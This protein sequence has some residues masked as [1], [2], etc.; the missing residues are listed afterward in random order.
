MKRREFVTLVGSLV[1]TWPLAARAQQAG[2]LPTIG[3]L[4]P[5]VVSVD[6]PRVAAFEQRLGELG[7]VDDRSGRSWDNCRTAAC[8]S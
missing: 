2:K 8:S 3:Y 1:A 4:G 5:N 7:W 6:R